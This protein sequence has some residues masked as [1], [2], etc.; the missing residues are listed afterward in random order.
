MKPGKRFNVIGSSPHGLTA[1]LV[2]LATS[3][4]A[5][6]DIVV[7]SAILSVLEKVDIPAPEAGILN[8]LAVRVG[9]RVQAGQAV[10]QIDPQEQKLLAELVNQDLLLA[11]RESESDISVR[12]AQKEHEVAR[13]EL[14]RATSV[15]ADFPN[16]VSAKEV[17]RLK[18]AVESTNLKIEHADFERALLGLRIQ[19][20]DADLKLAQHRVDRLAIAT[21]IPG[22]VAQIDKSAGEWVDKGELILRVVRVDRL[23]VEGYV[24]VADSKGLVGRPVEVEAIVDGGEP[25]RTVGKITFVSPEAEPVD[26]QVHFWA[27]VDNSAMQLRPGLSVSVKIRHAAV[28]AAQVPSNS[29]QGAAPLR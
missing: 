15:N 11:K 3:V 24:G 21:P 4:C 1:A 12:L 10:A 20:I 14:Q 26:A 16:T 28:N 25:I 17:D 29:R 23:K 9:A 19:R 13:V 18:L 8:S 27:E 6:Q 7:P 5:G 22:V 2:L